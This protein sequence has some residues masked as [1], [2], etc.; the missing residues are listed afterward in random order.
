MIYP[1]KKP[2]PRSRPASPQKTVRKSRPKKTNYARRKKE[3]LRAFGAVARRHWMREQACIAC[4]RFGF[5]VSAH[6]ESGGK[7]RRADASKT[8]P[9]CCWS[10][11]G[12]EGCH[13]KFDRYE[14]IGTVRSRAIVR[15]GPRATELAAQVDA[16]WQ[17]QLRLHEVAGAAQEVQPPPPP[18]QDKT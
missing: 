17:E 5:S 14:A 4:G 8:I 16:E 2:K 15:G 13:Q 3:N 6:I 10:R 7:S 18:S 1:V 12:V 11:M 9:L